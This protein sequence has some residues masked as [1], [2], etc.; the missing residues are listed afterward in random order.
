MPVLQQNDDESGYHLLD[1]DD[2]T[3]KIHDLRPEGAQIL[4]NVYDVKVGQAVDRE[5]VEKLVGLRLASLRPVAIDP[6]PEPVP[7][8]EPER[9]PEPRPPAISRPERTPEPRP[10]AISRPEP[11]P[12]R[13]PEP[14]R[15]RPTS[16]PLSRA[17]RDQERADPTVRPAWTKPTPIVEPRGYLVRNQRK[18]RGREVALQVLYQVEQNPGLP[19]AEIDQFL[20]RRLQED[21]LC[22]FAAGLVDG[23]KSNREAI[24]AMITEV[25]ENWRLDR[26]AAIDR[27][28]LRLGTYEM[29]FDAG[30]PPRSP[31]TKPW[32]SP[33]ATARR[34]RA[35]SSTA[36]STASSPPTT[37]A[38]PPRLRSSPTP[39]RTGPDR[40]PASSAGPSRWSRPGPSPVRPRTGR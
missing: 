21:K 7:E 27:N 26:M 2:E 39:R 3:P 10:P 35:G 34:S 25:A 20:R 30:V 6:E 17:S 24:D 18:T 40:W 29:L 36:S 23:V 38:R 22:E 13:S 37:P 5:T 16:G 32:K 15:S 12:R 1:P 31:S 9:T 33:S 14:V 19:A 4:L 8:P 11:T 28:I